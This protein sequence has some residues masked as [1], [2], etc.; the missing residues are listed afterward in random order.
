[1]DPTPITHPVTPATAA[2]APPHDEAGASEFGFWDLLDVINPLQHIPVVSTIYRSI[3]GDEL[4]GT[5]RVLGGMLFGGPIGG[6]FA[7]LNAI[8]EDTTG[9]D[10]G[11]HALAMAFGDDSA[12]GDGQPA[13]AT[14]GAP[15]VPFAAA[16]AGQAAAAPAAEPMPAGELLFAPPP[17]LTLAQQPVGAKLAPTPAAPAWITQALAQAQEVQDGGTVGVTAQPW[18][19]DAMLHALDKYADMAKERPDG[20]RE[21]DRD[22]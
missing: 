16:P 2:P 13:P 5:A 17:A 3:T 10:L 18:F 1:M 6:A 19:T 14:A 4:H 12:P 11:D 21:E 7:V 8:F 22:R 15:G 9:R 20:E